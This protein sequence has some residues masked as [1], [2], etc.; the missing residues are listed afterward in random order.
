MDTGS[1]SNRRS[2]LQKAGAVLVAGS[3]INDLA[4]PKQAN[5]S[6]NKTLKVGLIG[7]GGRGSG[8]AA[9]A[10]KADPDTVLT[11]VGDI[12]SQQAEQSLKEL[13]ELFPDR[14]KVTPENT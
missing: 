12:F 2:F 14:V 6:K 8:A 3:V 13:K 5:A 11:A 10:L 9:Q 4:F 1:K 7:C